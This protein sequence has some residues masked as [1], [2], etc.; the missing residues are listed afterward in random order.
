VEELGMDALAAEERREIL[1][2][3]STNLSADTL[4]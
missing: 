3:L 2:Y 4:R 1:G